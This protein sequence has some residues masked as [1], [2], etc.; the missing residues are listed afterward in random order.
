M[1]DCDYNVKV[2]LIGDDSEGKSYLAHNFCKNFF[3]TGYK[4]AIGVEFHVKTLSVFEKTMKIQLW[5][6]DIRER[7]KSQ[8]SFY[9]RGALGAIIISEILKSD[10]QYDLDDTIQMIKEQAG[11]IPIILLTFNPHSE[12]FQAVSGVET[13]LTADNLNG[14]TFTEISLTPIQN[15]EVIFNKLAEHIIE[16]CKISPPPRPL[17]RPPRTRTKFIINKYLKL[18]LEFGHTNIY[19]GGRL[20]KQCKFLLLDIPVTSTTDYNEIESIDEAAEKLDH[21]M[22]RGQP[23]KYH[24]SP[25]IE[26]WGHCSNLQVW[27]E[28]NYDSRILHSNL[29]FPLLRALVKVGDPLAKKVFKEEIA[30]RLVSG[31]PSVV[32]HLINQ[33]YLK[34]LNKEEINSLLDDRNFLKN[35]PKWFID[36]QDIPK[37]LSKRIKAKLNDLKCPSC[38]SKVSPA[39][40]KKFLE[41]NSIRCEFCSTNVIK[42]L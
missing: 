10:F 26:F 40:I 9:Y 35:L 42:G 23:R 41:G 3:T 31:Y 25:D 39:S 22:E 24:L 32:Q 18:K 5:E 17:K 30:L 33:D 38:G 8:A 37:W 14:L 15:P 21:S 11:D 7:F 34:Y 4:S 28:N 20:F 12:E 1:L 36:F 6:L 27:Y 2:I 29:A 19:V 13:M 16:R